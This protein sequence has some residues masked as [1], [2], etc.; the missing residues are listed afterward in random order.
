MSI[1]QKIIALHLH[2]QYEIT[3]SIKIWK[4]FVTVCFALCLLIWQFSFCYASLVAAW[5]YV[6]GIANIQVNSGV[7][8]KFL[9][10]GHFP[11]KLFWGVDNNGQFKNQFGYNS[12]KFIVMTK[13]MFCHPSSSFGIGQL[14][15]LKKIML[16]Q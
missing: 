5:N 11:A 9:V 7:A 4:N 3:A 12:L 16:G 1:E 13:P 8:R 6:D 14:V 10:M 15:S 2:Q